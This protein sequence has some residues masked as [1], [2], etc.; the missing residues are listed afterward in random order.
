M[1]ARK[2]E[3]KVANWSNGEKYNNKNYC[4]SHGYD[5]R[6][7]HT[8]EKFP[9]KM[10]GHKKDATKCDPM[11]GSKN[12]KAKVWEKGWKRVRG[13][14]QKHSILTFNGTVYNVFE[15]SYVCSNLT[16]APTTKNTQETKEENPAIADSGCKGNFMAVYAHLK[17]VKPSKILSIKNFL[18]G[19]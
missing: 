2:T 10:F 13:D 18:M 17:N 9:K 19:R 4:W 8:S 14:D 3:T 7:P 5:T 15:N 12:N 6:N 1:H 11:E 16:W